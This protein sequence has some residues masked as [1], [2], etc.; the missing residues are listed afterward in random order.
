MHLVQ[1]CCVLFIVQLLLSCLY[2]YLTIN[3][4]IIFVVFLSGM[5]L[6][7]GRFRKLVYER[8]VAAEGVSPTV[9]HRK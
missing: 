1:I 7:W 9:R 8:F 4:I 5:G 3:K 6:V 2:R